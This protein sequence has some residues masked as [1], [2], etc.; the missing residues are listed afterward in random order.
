V[1]QPSRVEI[2]VPQPQEPSYGG[3]VIV[4]STADPS[5]LLP[6]IRSAVQ[7]LDPNLPVFEVR[8]LED[9]LADNSSS[10]RLAVTLIGS[11]AL[12]ALLLAGIG[13]YGVVSY[14]VTQRRQEIGIRIALGASA[15]NVLSMVL[16]QGA[17]LATFGIIAGLAGAF[18]LTRMIAS[19]LFE[20]SAFD[21][22]IFA[23]GVIALGALVL[24][25]CWLPARRATRIDPL[26]ALRY[27]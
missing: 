8:Q 7:S 1:D 5:A 20:V 16:W 25:A 14:L 18:A 13:I 11:F 23:I 2:Y 17:R 19:L 9:I 15:Q 3:A 12:L 26:A 27:E 21:L 24:L 4:R 10:R 6:G 22:T